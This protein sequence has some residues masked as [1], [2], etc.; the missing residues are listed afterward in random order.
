MKKAYLLDSHA[1]IWFL[2]GNNKLSKKAQK[3][4]TNSSNECFVSIATLWEIGI[5]INLGKLHINISFEELAEVLSQNLIK[6][7][8]ITFEHIVALND[9]ENIHRDP[10]DR[11]IL[12]QSKVEKIKLVSKDTVFKKYD[13]V[14]IIW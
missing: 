12:C 9:L 10:F 13:N 7:L 8:P 2:E 4:I 14:D 11:L 5:K 1:L 6:T 3:I